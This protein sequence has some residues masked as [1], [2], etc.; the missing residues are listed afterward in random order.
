MGPADLKR[1]WFDSLLCAAFA[2]F[3]GSTFTVDLWAVTGRIHGDDAFARALRGY[4]TAADPLFGKMP[5][6][7]WALMAISL[8][9]FGPMDLLVVYALARRRAWIRVPGLMFAA[10]QMTAMTTYF[11]L[12]AYGDVPP[13]SWPI[14]IA[15]NAPYL[16]F[17]AL[18]ALRLRREP[19]F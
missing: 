19:L 7:V 2:C 10:A 14:V 15:A 9:V 1:R 12:E 17:P 8:F 11:L 18:L 5:F 16:V 6:Y 4:T 3:A 13:A